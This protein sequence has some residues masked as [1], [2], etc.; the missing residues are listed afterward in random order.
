MMK[1]E[2]E[3]VS[4]P[5]LMVETVEES[6]IILS[7]SDVDGINLDRRRSAVRDLKRCPLEG[8]Q[9]DWIQRCCFPIFF[10]F[11]QRLRL[12]LR[13][14]FEAERDGDDSRFGVGDGE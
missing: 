14:R 3:G 10:R 7:S 9:L 1:V 12:C 8:F 5:L 2:L 11:L 13:W 6:D 4:D